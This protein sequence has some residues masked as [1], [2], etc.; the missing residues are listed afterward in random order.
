MA[1]SGA[2]SV[3]TARCNRNSNH[4]KSRAEPMAEARSWL[5]VIRNWLLLPL[6]FTAGYIDALSY[7]G[8]A[9]YS[10]RT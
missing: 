8:W 6:A 3:P 9:A 10:R 1:P 7:S 4:V 5:T 2:T